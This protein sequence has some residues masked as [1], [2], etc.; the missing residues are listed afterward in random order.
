MCFC[1]GYFLFFFFFFWFCLPNHTIFDNNNTITCVIFIH[2]RQYYQTQFNWTKIVWMSLNKLILF[3]GFLNFK[4]KTFIPINAKKK[5]L[6]HFTVHALQISI[7][8]VITRKTFSQLVFRCLWNGLILS[9]LFLFLCFSPLQKKKQRKSSQKMVFMLHG[10]YSKF[11][12]CHLL[13][14]KREH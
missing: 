13:T 14:L 4:L 6:I 12:R 7:I 8:F 1:V 5:S 3:C 2:G 10:L 9:S 11:C